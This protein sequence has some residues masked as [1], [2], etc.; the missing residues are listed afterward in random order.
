MTDRI[1]PDAASVLVV[2]DEPYILDLLCSA[3]RLSGFDV[4]AADSGR[5]ALEAATRRPPDVMILDVI[6]PD[7][8]GFTV[9]K[10]LREQ[11]SEVPVLFL[12][13][14]DAVEDRIAGLRAGG[15][16][17]VSKPFSLEEVVLRLHA[18]LRR[19]NKPDADELPNRLRFADLELDAATHQVHRAGEQIW[20]SATEFKLLHYLMLNA[21]KV[22]SKRQILDRVW[23]AE[24]GRADRVVETFVSQL[25]RKVDTDHAPL[26]HTVRGVGYTLRE[27]D[28]RSAEAQTRSRKPLP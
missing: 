3:L 24:D 12:T 13:A 7:L 1:A 10:R 25:R 5:A 26:I 27:S 28:R 20:L 17:Y 6:L 11:G 2:D 16:D 22:V 9:A 21:G 23:Q 14:R 15:D 4:A 19:T 18:I 8:D